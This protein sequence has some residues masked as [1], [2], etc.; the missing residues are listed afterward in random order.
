[1][2]NDISLSN[3]NWELHLDYSYEIQYIYGS[4]IPTTSTSVNT[5]GLVSYSPTIE[6]LKQRPKKIP[7]AHFG[8]LTTDTGITIKWE[9]SS[10]GGAWK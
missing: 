9:R 3:P 5:S 4:T 6:A 7:E 2:A 10:S 8:Q 1:M